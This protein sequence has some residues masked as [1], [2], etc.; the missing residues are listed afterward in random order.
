MNRLIL[1]QRGIR[2]ALLVLAIPQLGIGV[3]AVA[4]PS[5]WFETFPGAGNNWLP[6]YGPYSE[7]LAVDVGTAFLAIGVMLT[8][9]A[10]WMDRR[11]VIAAAI[12]YLVYQVPHTIFHLGADDVLS[13][14]DQLANGIGLVLAVLLPPGIILG[15]IR[16]GSQT[17]DGEGSDP[18]GT[19]QGSDPTGTER[20]SD[21]RGTGRLAPPPGGIVA[22]LSRS[23]ARRRFG[24]ELSPVD[25]YLHH[26]RL[27][28]GYSAFETATERSHRVDA[29][30]KLLAELK[31]AAVVGCEWCMD[32]GSH[33]AR[34]E[35]VPDRQM[36]ELPLYRES[37]A[38]DER[39]RLV[40]EFAAAMSRTPAEVGDELFAR[41]RGHFDDA[42]LVELAN[43]I[44]IE[45]FRARFNHA[46]GLEPQGFSEG[47]ACVVP[48]LAADRGMQQGGRMVSGLDRQSRS[49][50]AV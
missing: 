23:Y 41:L 43:V 12:A 34:L 11:L 5:G 42:Q 4:S 21:P 25:A 38:F 30:L 13:S 29:R 40:I 10:V 28:V 17:H 8:L 22:R 26:R 3:W 32:F 46:L 47:A 7:H 45:N 6:L 50:D 20:G 24:R 37:D 16:T 27:L 33:L 15:A 39:E 1:G 44:A 48:E 31:A 2:V 36:R 19:E 49:P 14:G 18:T 35:G 9:A